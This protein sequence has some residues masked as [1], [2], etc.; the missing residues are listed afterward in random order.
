[1]LADKSCFIGQYKQ[2]R[3]LLSESLKL[4]APADIRL[5]INLLLAK[6]DFNE[7][8]WLEAVKVATQILRSDPENFE[9]LQVRQ[10]AYAALGWTKEDIADCRL[11]LKLKPQ[12][13]LHQR[14][15]I[16]LNC[17]SATTPE[18]LYEESRHWNN[19]YAAQFLK[20]ILPHRN[21]VDAERRLKIGYV[22]PDLRNHA[23]MKLLPGVL[24]HHDKQHFE[25]FAYAID[26]K[27]NDSTAQV[28]RI[29]DHFIDLPAS[30]HEIASQIRADQ[31]DILVDLAGHT[32]A[33]EAL[34]AYA[35]KP[36]PVQIT[37]MGMLA[38]TGL[39]TMDYFIGDA[40]MP[41][42][43]TEHAFS[44][45]VYRLPR[46]H[47]CY[48]PSEDAGI[49]AAPCLKNG[50]ITF[51]SFNDPRK[52][53]RDV[54]T[55]WSVILH[56]HPDSRLLL[57]YTNLDQE[58]VQ[59]RIRDSFLEDGIAADRLEF[60]GAGSALEFQ[61]TL[62]QVDIA[63]D[64]FPYVGGTTT[65][66]TL[67]MGVPVISLA[68]RLAVSAL[69]NSLLS[70]VGLPVANSLEQY[71]AL[72]ANVV[73]A[74]PGSPDSRARLRRAMLAST[75]MDGCGMART[76]EAAYRDMWRTWCSEQPAPKH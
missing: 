6:L 66:E 74:L 51:G 32:M 24:E 63:L 25:I 60:Q 45:K 10:K 14:L 75:L 30:R 36:A 16:K 52:I 27:R 26:T 46:F 62:N 20:D 5:Q 4:N 44:E 17:I 47:A 59:Q 61:Q 2:A 50:F 39:S 13:E 40:Q 19:L 37:W 38:T 35:C 54:V 41:C 3:E 43:G 12:P 71:I 22:S 31:I 33:S 64:P 11:L 55:V 65:L 42:P 23:I 70:A 28:Q 48:R 72:A 1:M 53:S 29:V 76:M 8:K 69:S 67:W 73:K 21:A 18:L 57:K 58:L 49:T 34:L 9:A 15:L 56:F 7:D 68:G